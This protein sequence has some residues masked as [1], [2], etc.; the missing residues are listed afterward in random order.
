MKTFGL[1]D[2]AYYLF[3]PF[4]YAIDAIWLTDL[5]HCDVCKARRKRWNEALSV[6]RWLAVAG[7]TM[8]VVAATWRIAR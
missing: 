3:R 2:L 4:A 8:L 7:L 6:P 1:G 5:R